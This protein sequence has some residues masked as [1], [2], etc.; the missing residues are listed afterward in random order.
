MLHTVPLLALDW[1]QIAI[2]LFIIL[3]SLASQLFKPNPQQQQQQPERRR[4][5]P[6]PVPPQG[7]PAARVEAQPAARPAAPA[8]A[9]GSRPRNA[10]QDEI[11]TFLRRATGQ[12]PPKPDVVPAEVVPAPPARERKRPAAAAGQKSAAAQ[13]EKRELREQG[14]QRESV[15]EHVARRMHDGGLE[16]REAGLGGAIQQ[17]E[18]RIGSHLDQVFDHQLGQLTGASGTER[19]A[20]KPSTA[21]APADSSLPP[22]TISAARI[23]Q[24]LR[25]P[26][27]LATAI[28]LS[29][30]LQRPVHRWS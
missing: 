14:E 25:S 27:D 18:R 1:L 9:K 24:I 28:V 2:L 22:S 10:V 8:A 17:T 5:R 3:S 26:E 11:E 6:R 13:R 12:E 23:A 15:A 30:I 21:P 19:T 7:A 20:A 16:T 4:N 29:E